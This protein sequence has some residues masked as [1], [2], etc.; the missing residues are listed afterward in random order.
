[1]KKSAKATAAIR[2]FFILILMIP[3]AGCDCFQETTGCVYDAGS[4][5]PVEHA[6]VCLKEKEY[7]STFTDSAGQFHLTNITGGLWG[8]CRKMNLKITAEGYQAVE[9]TA[10]NGDT[11]HIEIQPLQ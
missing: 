5:M 1:M 4:G 8:D 7:E 9:T 2:F 11:L 10:G 6:K 3:L